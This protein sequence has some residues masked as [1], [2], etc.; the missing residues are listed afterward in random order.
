MRSPKWNPTYK[1]V[2]RKNAEFEVMYSPLSKMSFSPRM[3]LL[4]WQWKNQ[5]KPWF[6]WT[7]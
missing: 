5:F 3:G 7:F 2:P 1:K 6:E 4:E